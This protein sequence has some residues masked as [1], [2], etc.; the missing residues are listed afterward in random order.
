M[1]FL[2]AVKGCIR[3]DIIRNDPIR[4][5]LDIAKSLNE[6]TSQHK[7]EWWLHIERI[8]PTRFPRRPLDYHPSGKRSEGSPRKRWLDDFH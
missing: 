7:K 5:K 1:M 4:M 2:T 3:R 8:D 6:K